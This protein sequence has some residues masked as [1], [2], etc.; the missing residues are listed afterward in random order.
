MRA[1]IEA[2]AMPRCY[3]CS[4]LVEILFAPCRRC[5]MTRIG[6]K[7]SIRVRKITQAMRQ[8]C[9]DVATIHRRC[10]SGPKHDRVVL[11]AS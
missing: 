6:S 4:T 2:M 5:N 8:I 1:R 9:G 7:M 11:M 3:S 10:A